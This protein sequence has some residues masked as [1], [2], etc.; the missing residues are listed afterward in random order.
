MN[1]VLVCAK[2]K[3]SQPLQ[4]FL[5]GESIAFKTL[6][7]Q[8]ICK[9]PVAACEVKGRLEWFAGVTKTKQYD[10][11]ADLARGGKTIPSVLEKRRVE[12]H[13]GRSP[14]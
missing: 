12:K 7:C 4:R 13:S 14:R 8:K 1:R 9:E 11:L 6:G 3:G 2:C 10:A 5:R